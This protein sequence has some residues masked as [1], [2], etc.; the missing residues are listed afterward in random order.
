MAGTFPRFRLY[1]SDGSTPVFEFDSVVDWGQS[2]FEDPGSFSEH[3]SL[4]GQGS[5]ISDG[6]DLP[7]DLELNFVL[8]EA[9]Y[10]ALVAIMTVLPTTIAKNTNYILKVDLTS[11][12]TKDLK[13]KR[14]VPIRFPS[15]TRKKKVQTFA[16]GFIV[17]RVDSWA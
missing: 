6:A 9:D 11:S 2:P 5:I 13:V 17:F 7:W 10:E 12:T 3:T 14:L 4:R 16:D 15:G 8:I 1:E